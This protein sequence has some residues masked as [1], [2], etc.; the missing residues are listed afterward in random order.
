MAKKFISKR[1]FRIIMSQTK[2]KHHRLAFK[3]S[4]E[5]GLSSSEVIKLKPENINLDERFIKFGKRIIVFPD[6]FEMNLKLLPISKFCGSRAIQGAFKTIIRKIGIG[7]FSYRDLK[8]AFIINSLADGK[9]VDYINYVCNMKWYLFSRARSYYKKTI[10]LA[11]RLEVFNRDNYTCK[12]CGRNPKEDNIKIHCDHII[13]LIKGG[14]SEF[15]NL[16]TLCEDCNYG[17]GGDVL[18]AKN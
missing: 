6:N 9:S 11:R 2:I 5:F 13:P 7:D 15:D 8:N 17:K 14:T 10:P 4:Y 3:I 1:N 16:Q 18:L 12:V